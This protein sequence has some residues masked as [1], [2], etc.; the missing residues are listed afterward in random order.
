MDSP[1]HI[2]GFT[3]LELSIVLV[4]IGLIIGGI[5][6]GQELIRSAELNSVVSDVSKYKVAINTFKLKYNALPGDMGNASSYWPTCDAT[7]SNCDGDQNGVVDEPEQR[8]FWQ[9]LGLAEVIAGN[10]TGVFNGS[11]NLEVG[12]NIPEGRI[13]GTGYQPNQGDMM[14]FPANSACTAFEGIGVSKNILRITYGRPEAGCGRP[15]NLAGG[16]L[17]PPEA[18]IIDSKYDDGIPGSGKIIAGMAQVVACYSF[19]ARTEYTLQN[20]DKVCM[21][22]FDVY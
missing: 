7:P 20:T 3:L 13:S 5:T 16:A 12:V 4:I 19:P 10:Y 9:H 6:A 1:K 22:V 17:S 15:G 18:S 8:R 11:G 2:Q 21:L 14:Q